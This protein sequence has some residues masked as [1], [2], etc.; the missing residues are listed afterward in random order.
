MINL[1]FLDPDQEVILHIPCPKEDMRWKTGLEEKLRLEDTLH[2]PRQDPSH[3][4]ILQDS[5]QTFLCNHY[6]N[7]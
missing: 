4:N 3:L 5:I 2:T 1:R 6:N 7:D